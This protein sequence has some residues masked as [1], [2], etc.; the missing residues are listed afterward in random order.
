MDRRRAAAFEV[1]GIP[2]DSEV[3]A[4]VRAYRRLA[5]VT[6]PDVSTDPEAGHRFACLAAAYK[7][8]AQTA[9]VVGGPASMARSGVRHRDGD[10]SEHADGGPTSG[11]DRGW[12]S[13]P[14]WWI[15]WGPTPR[16]GPRQDAPIVAGPVFIG[17]ARRPG[18]GEVRGG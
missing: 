4:V 2:A 15:S 9:A 12:R 18:H 3:N 16:H 1:L 11:G 8:A 5:R 10:V 14:T 13:V 6:H 7:V 17:P